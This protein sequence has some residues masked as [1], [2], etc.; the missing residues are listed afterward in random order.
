MNAPDSSRGHFARQEAARAALARAKSTIPALERDRHAALLGDSD[1]AA[2]VAI[3]DQIA[4]QRRILAACLDRITALSRPL[5]GPEQDALGIG[6][7]YHP[8]TGM[9]LE[10]GLGAF[11]P[12]KQ[13]R[14]IH[15]PIIAK[16]D[17]EA[18]AAA[19]LKKINAAAAA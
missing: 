2:V 7:K 15:L 6:G 4:H 16:R 19:M 10:D 18:V 14:E 9:M 17:G 8:I 5:S 1:I 11:A 12:D 13:A 3:D